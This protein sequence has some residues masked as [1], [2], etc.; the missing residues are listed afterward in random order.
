MKDSLYDAACCLVM[1]PTSRFIRNK[2]PNYI[3]SRVMIGARRS[4]RQFSAVVP[5]GEL[6]TVEPGYAMGKCLVGVSVSFVTA[7]LHF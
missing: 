3:V 2:V 5:Y 6:G 1:N 4:G 7:T